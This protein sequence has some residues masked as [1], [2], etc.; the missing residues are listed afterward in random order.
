VS[1]LLL[2]LALAAAP[3]RF[4]DA[5]R[6]ALEAHPALRVA[7]AEAKRARAQLEVARA[8]SLPSL[9]VNA[10]G[11]Q[12]DADREL[13]GRVISA[14]TQLGANVNLQVPLVAPAR[15]AGWRRAA[16]TADAAVLGA[17]DARRVVAVTAGRAW[18]SVLAQQ[19]VVAGGERA[20]S[21]AGA[22]L[23]Y[24]RD[25]RA[26]GLGTELDEIRAAQEV[27]VARQQL[28]TARGQLARLQEQLGVAVGADEALSA[29]DVE[30]ALGAPAAADERLDVRAARGRLDAAKVGASWEWAD[31]LPLLT[32]VV[33]P[34]YQNPPTLTVPLWNFQAQL[35]LSIPLYDG[36]LRY[37]QQR[38]RRAAAEQAAALVEQVERQANAEVRAAMAQVKQADEA[39]AA[40]RDAAAQ[41]ARTLTLAQDAFR[42]GAST[43]LEVV[44][45][46]RRARDADL[47][48][49]LAE[50]AA[51]Q[52]RLELL[53]ASG[54][55]PTR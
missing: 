32:A 55:F 53:A 41:A 12:L 3:V 40:A 39:L 29:E 44:D 1:P 23:A 17:A 4:D 24:A 5:V 49:A 16:A 54:A 45:A 7:E 9:S 26:A 22:H 52:A 27:A 19:R 47:A 11:T 21:V 42:A 37:A 35:V 50:D 28:A 14:A 15:W 30:P 31:Y 8:P 38:E 10:V 13:N 48:V 36:G 25:R 20:L 2:S 33:Q 43:N 46:E 34:G 18:L 6:R 51:R